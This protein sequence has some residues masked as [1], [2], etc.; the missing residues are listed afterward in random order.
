MRNI[1]LLLFVLSL[2]LNAHSQHLEINVIDENNQPV[3]GYSV[4]ENGFFIKKHT[5]EKTLLLEVTHNTSL[6][7]KHPFYNSFGFQ[8]PTS[9]KKED[10]IRQLITLSPKHQDFEEIDII[11]S[12]Y[13]EVFD[14][15]NEFILD[16]CLY[17]KKSIVLLTRMNK[18]KYLKL[19]R[20]E[21]TID[22]L[23]L[24]FNPDH[25]FRDARGNF[26]V[27]GKE[28]VVQFNIINDKFSFQK[29]ESITDF[30]KTLK[31][32]ISLQADYAVYEH[33]SMHNQYYSLIKIHNGNGESV[34]SFLANEKY[35]RALYHYNKT[36]IH[37]MS[38]IPEKDNVILMGLWDG[39]LMSLNSHPNTG[40]E[41][42]GINTNEEIMSLT[43]WSDKI[44]S[45]PINIKAFGLL[46]SLIVLNSE[47]D[48]IIHLDYGNLAIKEEIP[49]KSNLSGDYY[50]DYFYNQ[51]FIIETKNGK[52]EVYALNISNGK[53]KLIADLSE[54][55][56]P[57]NIKIMNNKVY[58][59]VLD[60]SGFNRLLSVN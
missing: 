31:N 57:R 45:K 12:K 24:D 21:K 22:S 26:F 29:K 58:F 18:Q 4:Y 47:C 30:N 59:L 42:K 34:Y 46:E 8:I 11:G 2:L 40:L 52:K 23:I 56:Q 35:I 51:I 15:K 60:K 13:Q 54:I 48:S 39:D 44:T 3:F 53:S 14:E 6:E 25:L 7:V 37:Y 50:F 10:T 16:Y 27:V 32:A 41:Q 20:K 17:P 5:N 55:Y 38:I 1:T 43:S 36:V 19:L 9:V 49:T 28:N 33:F